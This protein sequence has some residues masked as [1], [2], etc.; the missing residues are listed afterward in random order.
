MNKQAKALILDQS[1]QYD[2]TIEEILPG[3]TSNKVVEAMAYSSA[4]KL[5]SIF[6]QAM[7]IKYL[8]RL[9]WIP[10]KKINEALETT[11]M[12]AEAVDK[13]FLSEL[14]KFGLIERKVDKSGDTFYRPALQSIEERT[15]LFEYL[16]TGKKPETQ[17]EVTINE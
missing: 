15:N 5:N 4:D 8:D 2:K 11:G 14:V 7:I 10:V 3:M 17:T 16:V 12:F 6:A 13:D 9:S 1:E